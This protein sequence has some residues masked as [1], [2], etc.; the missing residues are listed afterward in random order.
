MF[1]SGNEVSVYTPNL[2]DLTK[3]VI[4][5]EETLNF[6]DLTD[7]LSMPSTSD[8]L[9]HPVFNSGSSTPRKQI[10][11]SVKKERTEEEDEDFD[12]G[13]NTPKVMLSP[14]NPISIGKK[15]SK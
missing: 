6:D 12:E 1:I 9:D 4:G 11:L 7:T 2:S 8:L 13:L 5:S 3:D 15:R 14:Y 10:K